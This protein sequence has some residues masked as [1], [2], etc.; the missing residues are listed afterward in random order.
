MLITEQRALENYH[1]CYDNLAYR[2]V[3][4]EMLWVLSAG[5][6][7]D[8]AALRQTPDYIT[9]SNLLTTVALEI[10]G[11]PAYH[12]EG[13][14]LATSLLT[15][16]EP[17]RKSGDLTA[18]QTQALF[19]LVDGYLGQYRAFMR[20]QTNPNAIQDILTAQHM[21]EF[22]TQNA[23]QIA[24]WQGRTAY[25]LAAASASLLQVAHI[26]LTQA[27]S[28]S[29]T[30]YAAEKLRR[31]LQNLRFALQEIRLSAPSDEPLPTLFADAETALTRIKEAV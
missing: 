22:A 4:D 14:Q 29:T 5:S 6:P 10:C 23:S 27:F 24:R 15:I 17:R 8:E 7:L 9:L 16:T 2:A 25:H 18:Q 26:I 20:Q 19:D 30:F 31:G 12:G 28:R 13:W 3:C 1:A 11:H 21:A